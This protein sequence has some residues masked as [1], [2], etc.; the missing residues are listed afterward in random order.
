MFG[1][2]SPS[3]RAV[4]ETGADLGLIEGE[5]MRGVKN[6]LDLNKKSIFLV[7]DFA[8]GRNVFIPR[9]VRCD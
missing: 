8:K 4:F 5:N 1:G 9:Q 2:L 3:M 7:A 6:R